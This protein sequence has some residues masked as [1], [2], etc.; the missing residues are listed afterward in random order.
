MVTI[1]HDSDCATHNEPA[2]P[3]GPC[4]CGADSI[5]KPRSSDQFARDFG[6]CEAER[7]KY[8]AMLERIVAMAPKE[9][10]PK[11][12]EAGLGY[13]SEGNIDDIV[14]DCVNEELWDIAELIRPILR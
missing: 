11:A 9:K 2:Y 7:D 14:E 5:K 12:L 10:P 8:K 1:L 13:R 6:L 4:D 3:N